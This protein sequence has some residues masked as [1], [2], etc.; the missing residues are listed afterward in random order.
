[1]VDI[2]FSATFNLQGSLNSQVRDPAFYLGKICSITGLALVLTNLFYMLDLTSEDPKNLN[3]IDKSFLIEGIKE[4]TFQINRQ[5]RKFN[6]VFQF[7]LYF[8]ITII[9]IC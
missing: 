7:K 1:M 5:V 6:V 8:M 2:S 3:L 9:V 4:E